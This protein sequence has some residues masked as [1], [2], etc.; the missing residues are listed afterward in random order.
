MAAPVAKSAN[1]PP[2]TG[3]Q[4][5]WSKQQIELA[6]ARCKVL[7][8][9]LDVVALP[10]PPLHEGSECGTAAPMKLLSIGKN[11]Q[12][13]LSPPPTVTCDMIAALHKW[14]QHDIQALSK[15]YLGSPVIR[16]ETM[17]SYSCRNAYGRAHGKLSEHGRANALDIA[18]FITAKAQVARVLSDWGP[19]AREIETQVAAAKAAAEKAAAA[20]PAALPPQPPA[21]PAPLAAFADSGAKPGLSIPAFA[22]GLRGTR[23]E[24]PAAMGLMP[25]SRLGGPKPKTAAVAPAPVP[26]GDAISGKAMFLRAAHRAACTVFETALGPEANT[27]HRNHFH[28]DMAVRAHETVICE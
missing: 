17:S 4:S 26:A 19:T 14:I 27:W 22:L 16:L 1:T 25:A 6:Q 24:L 2:A 9:G 21:E 3:A 11:P 13:A 7:L 8:K 23:S 18:A 5:G 12:V 20:A 28:V 15:K 10:E